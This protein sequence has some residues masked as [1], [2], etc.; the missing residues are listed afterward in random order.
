MGETSTIIRQL[1]S[2]YL[3]QSLKSLVHTRIQAVKK[4]QNDDC[5]LPLG[6]FK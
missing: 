2:I 6:L 4:F 1:L 5:F 3:N